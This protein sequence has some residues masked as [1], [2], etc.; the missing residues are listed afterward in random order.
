MALPRHA[1]AVVEDLNEAHV[2]RARRELDAHPALR[3]KY[4]KLVKIVAGLATNEARRKHAIGL[5]VAEMHGDEKKYGKKSVVTLATL[6]AIDKST[7]NDYARVA[8]AWRTARELTAVLRERNTVGIPITFSHLVEIAGFVKEQRG[9]LLKLVRDNNLTVEQLR[10]AMRGPKPETA[11]HDEASQVRHEASRWRAQIDQINRGTEWVIV[12]ASKNPTRSVLDELNE[13]AQL[14]R[15]LSQAA[16]KNADRLDQERDRL[17][18]RPK[19]S[20]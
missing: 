20:A 3:H 17:A 6:L 1:K 7:L 2:R 12:R 18:K 8:R 16:S 9:R 10:V 4:E 19:A 15:Q 13:F 5:T 11:V 14:Q